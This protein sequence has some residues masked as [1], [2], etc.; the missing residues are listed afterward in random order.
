M[1]YDIFGQDVTD[2]SGSSGSTLERENIYR[3]GQLLVTSEPGSGGPKN[4][5]WTNKVGVL[6]SGNNLSKPDPDGW[7]AG[8]SSTQ[9]ITS[10]DGYV[11]FTASETNKDRRIGLSHGDSN[12]S[13]DDIDF[14]IYL[15]ADG[16][17]YINENATG[18]E[19]FG[20]YATGDV[21][22]VS[23]ESGVVK[24]R[25]NGTVVYTSTISPTYP[26][27]VDT[28]LYSNGATLTN[29]VLESDVQNVNWA[30][31]VGVT[32][33]GNNLTKP[34]PDGWNAGASST[35]SITSGDGYVEFT[36]SETNKHRR[37][38]LSNGDSNQSYDDID[39]CIYLNA[40][41]T[42]YINE[43]ATGRG[44]FGSYATGDVFRVAVE[45]GVVKY[46]KN[47][48]VVYTSTISPTY[49]LLVDTSLYSNGATLTNVV[50]AAANINDSRLSYVLSDIRGST[51]ALL[52]N[53]GSASA[54]IARHDYLPFGEELSSGLG[55][56]SSSQGYGATDRNRQK[57]GLTERDDATGLD[58]TWW[59]KY[60]NLEW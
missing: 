14:C 58:H 52:S 20:S 53:G 36:A 9:S 23:V 3:G 28:S 37:I 38:G 39:F 19:N 8:A 55:L 15:N 25:K 2:Y 17:F 42:F 22:R 18:R 54:I 5:S 49:P 4:V 6:S 30:N 1:V 46:R 48:T 51:R 7:N 44:N 56:R 40:D 47:G 24:Y 26:L 16:T 31:G 12:Q 21:F 43:N 34:D 29:V 11:E 41:G 33:S 60:E 45:S 13:Y 50:I 57:Y 59:R 10:G 27:L 35:Q 32:A